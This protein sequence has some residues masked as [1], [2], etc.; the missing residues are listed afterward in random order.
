MR[1]RFLINFTILFLVGNAYSQSLSEV[2]CTNHQTGMLLQTLPFRENT[3]IPIEDVINSYNS[4]ENM[5]TRI[6][7]KKF[8]RFIYSNPTAARQYLESGGFLKECTKIREASNCR[9]GLPKPAC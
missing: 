8:I 9:G 3:K 6:F 4:E 7:L 5:D 1:L 2:I